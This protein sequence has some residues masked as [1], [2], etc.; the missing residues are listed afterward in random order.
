MA[1]HERKRQGQ[2]QRIRL[3]CEYEKELG[4][5]FDALENKRK[6]KGSKKEENG[7]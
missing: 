1:A 2:V 7:C 3:I 4:R 6:N 5:R